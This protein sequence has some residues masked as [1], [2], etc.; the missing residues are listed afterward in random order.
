MPRIICDAAPS[1]FTDGTD[2]GNDG[3][4]MV[5]MKV[6]LVIDYFDLEELTIKKGIPK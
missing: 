1:R 5:K 4:K 2:S 6:I 3:D